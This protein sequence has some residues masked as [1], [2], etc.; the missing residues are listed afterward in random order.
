MS[1]ER[2]R[3]PRRRTEEPAGAEMRSY[4][5]DEDALL[6][7]MT[8]IP[9]Y[10]PYLPDAMHMHNCM[11]IGLCLAGEGMLHLGR[12]QTFA[13]SPGALVLVPQG[14]PHNQVHAGSPLTHWRY[15]ALNED[16]LLRRMPRRYQS[17]LAPLLGGAARG[18]IFLPGGGEGGAQAL[19]SLMFSL[20]NS[21][22]LHTAQQEEL[23]ALLLLTL[24]LHQ[25]QAAPAPETFAPD[26]LST[27]LPLKPALT[28]VR[29]HYREDVKIG[30]M[31]RSC[32]MSESYFRRVFSK[33]MGLAPLEFVNRYRVQRSMYL[34][35][36]TG[37]PVQ[38]IAAQVGF[39][40][41]AAFNRNFR[42]FA[43]MSPVAWRRMQTVTNPMP[44]SRH[45]EQYRS[46]SAQD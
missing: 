30:D 28:Y 2:E 46:D 20:R 16:Y 23:C 8:D 26:T 39:S 33:S 45:P 15:I 1:S 34:L 42:R 17:E 21:G 4:P 36:I 22:S 19:F 10:P 25:A 13:F 7:A 14:V 29:E 41:I 44:D 35:R 31:A 12:E 6:A 27:R 24:L 43:S 32:S 38:N 18:G 5:V 11:E 9:F 3:P 37:D 40:S